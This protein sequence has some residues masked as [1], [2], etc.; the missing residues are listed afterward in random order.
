MQNETSH[1]GTPDD[2]VGE[3]WMSAARRAEERAAA[4]ASPEAA[5]SAEPNAA[6]ADADPFGFDRIVPSEWI[7]H[8]AMLAA[9]LDLAARDDANG[10]EVRERAG[11]LRALL[12]RAR[13]GGFGTILEATVEQT[14][15]PVPAVEA[16]PPA[17]YADTAPLMVVPLAYPFDQKERRFDRLE[18]RPP[19][20]GMVERVVAG[21]ATEL[22][23]HAEMSGITPAAFRALRWADAEMAIAAA[24]HIAPAL[25][26]R[27]A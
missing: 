27:K 26:T 20:F 16:I 15:E 7:G 24:R 13:D 21:D 17:V 5:A 18:F 10:N 19:T 8:A 1:T 14:A 12:S 22:D 6:V 23:M 3:D 25:V 4:D 9:H 2:F 11:E